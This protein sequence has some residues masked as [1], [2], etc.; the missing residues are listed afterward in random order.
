MKPIL[1]KIDPGTDYSFSIREDIH[2]YLYH[3]WHYH[4]EVE[5]TFIRKGN[6]IRLVG[7]SMQPFKDG[8]LILLG[9][10][11]PHLWRSD[12]S[13]F[14][15]SS[16]LTIEAI[17]VHFKAEFWGDA[18]LALPEM[19]AVNRLLERAQRGIRVLGDTHTRVAAKMEEIICT[20]GVARI[21]LLLHMLNLIAFSDECESLSS[22]GFVQTFNANNT[23]RIDQVFNY[24]FTHFKEP[25][26][27]ERVASAVSLSPHSFCRY[28]K[29]RTLKTY[30]Q[31]LLEVRIGY[32]CKLLIENKQNISHIA[33][34]S[35]F[36]NLS[37]FNRQFKAIMRLTPQ[38]YLKAYTAKT[39]L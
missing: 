33:F 3:H 15:Q 27:I 31:F 32:A 18:F 2:P 5:L 19:A 20:Q 36:S 4:P 29:T 11:V 37:N 28:F 8:D 10:N 1:R 35:G 22:A 16:E 6:G 30:W 34:E 12:A 14:E 21:E 9:A 25:L 26:S 17:A 38:Q 13:Y 24:T 23:D 7:D 39:Q